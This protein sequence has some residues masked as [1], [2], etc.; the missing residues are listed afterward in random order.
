MTEN[1]FINTL[2]L[3]FLTIH[4]IYIF[5][6]HLPKRQFCAVFAGLH[7]I[8]IIIKKKVINVQVFKYIHVHLTLDTYN[9]SIKKTFILSVAYYVQ[10]Q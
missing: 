6:Y 7:S 5:Y 8:I 1:D 4:K 2:E 3:L 9:T 10:T